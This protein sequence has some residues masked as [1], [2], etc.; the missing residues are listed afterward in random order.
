MY[1]MGA[2]AEE[3]SD[4]GTGTGVEHETI[5]G[6]IVEPFDP[7]KIDVVTKPMTVDLLLSRLESGA[8]NLAPDFQRK[9]GIWSDQRQSSLIES[10]LLRIPLPS[11][12]A[13]EDDD[14]SWEVVDGIQR[15]T[16][17]ARFVRPKLLSS[18]QPLR[19]CG[20]EYLRGEVK[21]GVPYDGATF[22]DL[23]GRLQ[24]R[25]RETEFVFHLIRAGTPPLVKFNIFARINTG[26]MPLSYQELR[27]ALVPGRAR[28]LVRE[29]AASDAFVKA[30]A[31]SVNTDRMADREMV[32]R[33]LAFRLTEYSH[34]PSHGDLNKFLLETMRALNKIDPATLAEQ[35]A[36]FHAALTT[37]HAIWG[38]DAF[39]KRHSRGAPRSPVNKSLFEA[40]TVSLAAPDGAQR[41]LLVERKEAVIDAF[42]KE[43]ADPAFSDAVSTATG[44]A[45]KVKRRFRGIEN[46]FRSVLS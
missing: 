26:G 40:I 13:S 29:W 25:I 34:Y 46:V 22:E 7:E 5:R 2:I 38:E 12:Y 15:L 11:F 44:D 28:D 39:R 31:G 9:A 41:A 21:P 33:F 4:L 42:I 19:L 14:E 23:S 8:L 20:L 1:T 37:A 10:L 24:R 16:S 3:L 6:D 43:M 35:E 18:G 27:H 36:A 30:T 17:I 32:L 45:R